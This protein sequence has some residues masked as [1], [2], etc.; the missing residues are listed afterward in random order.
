MI[1]ITISLVSI[2]L[3]VGCAPF[4]EMAEEMDRT[5]GEL[6]LGDYYYSDSLTLAAYPT[7][8]GCSNSNARCRAL[9]DYEEKLYEAAQ[10]GRITY[11]QLVN[12]F[13]SRRQEL[14]PQIGN[15]G[16]VR[17]L[18]AFQRALAEARDAGKVTETQWEYYI[19]KKNSELAAR[20]QMLENT[21]PRQTNCITINKG[22]LSNP[23][24]ETVC[25]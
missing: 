21:K 14:F 24:Y 17:E 2:A 23:K 19:E 5:A 7:P 3:L 20:A 16:Q 4:I 13:Y 25:Q 1:R 22:T 12:A 8:S 6:L 10:Q 18:H 11:V 15:S 9:D